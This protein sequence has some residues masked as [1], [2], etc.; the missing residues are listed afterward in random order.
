MRSPPPLCSGREMECR[1]IRGPGSC[2][3]DGSG[4]SMRSDAAPGMTLRWQHL[5]SDSIIE[6]PDT[7][8]TFDD[9]LIGDDRLRLIFHLL[10]SGA[11]TEARLVLTLREVCG[12][13]YQEIA[14]AFLAARRRLRSGW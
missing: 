11:G 5:P 6:P 12:L 9:D 10:P 4:R 13:T 3:Q 1:R 8:P 7:L 2:R 14:R